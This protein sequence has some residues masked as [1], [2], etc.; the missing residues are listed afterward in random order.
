M[1]ESIYITIFLL[2]IIHA[3]IP[4]L[5]YTLWNIVV[6]IFINIGMYTKVLFIWFEFDSLH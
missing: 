4:S 3:N 5:M 2:H 6:N 1:K